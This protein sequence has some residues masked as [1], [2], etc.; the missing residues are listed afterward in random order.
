MFYVYVQYVPFA[1]WKFIGKVADVKK[2][3]AYRAKMN[4]LG[5]LVRTEWRE[6]NV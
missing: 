4:S 6:E 2:V 5:A 1:P 3:N